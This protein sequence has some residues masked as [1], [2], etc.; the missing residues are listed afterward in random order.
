MFLCMTYYINYVLRFTSINHDLTIGWSCWRDYVGESFS[1][2]KAS[3]N[4]KYIIPNRNDDDHAKQEQALRALK[5][6]EPCWTT[7]T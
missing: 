6:T 5:T 2:Q 4:L 7:C 3:S 1:T